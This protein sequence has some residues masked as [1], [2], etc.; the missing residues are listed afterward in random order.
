MIAQFGDDAGAGFFDT[1]ADHEALLTRPKDLYDNAT[2]SGNSVAAETLLR[3]AEFTGEHG[4]RQRAQRLL[5]GLSGAMAR[6]PT[7]FGHLLC[8]LDFYLTP[9]KEIALAGDPNAGDTR[10]L[11]RTI[12]GRYLPNKVVALRP[13]GA[14]GERA[15]QLIPLLAD[16]PPLDSRATAYVCQ[17]FTCR[18]PVTDPAALAAQLGDER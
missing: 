1:S 4:Y 15:A 14:E 12:F 2:P 11:A 18:L 7:A 6:H 17:H 16:R 3:L 13:P 8:A 5:A 9:T 10:A